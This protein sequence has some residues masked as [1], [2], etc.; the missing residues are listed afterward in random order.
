MASYRDLRQLNSYHQRISYQLNELS[1]IA[2]NSSKNKFYPINSRDLVKITDSIFPLI[3]SIRRNFDRY[4]EFIKDQTVKNLQGKK[5]TLLSVSHEKKDPLNIT[6]YKTFNDWINTY[7]KQFLTNPNQTLKNAILTTIEHA[8]NTVLSHKISLWGDR[9][10]HQ[11]S[12]LSQIGRS[13]H[14]LSISKQDYYSVYRILEVALPVFS[15]LVLNLNELKS[16]LEK[17]NPSIEGASLDPIYFNTKANTPFSLSIYNIY[18]TWIVNQSQEFVKSPTEKL[19][20]SICTT[21]DSIQNS[22]RAKVLELQGIFY[23][24][25]LQLKNCCAEEDLHSVLRHINKIA[26]ITGKYPIG[27]LLM[28]YDWTHL[29]QE[30]RPLEEMFRQIN[31][32]EQWV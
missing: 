4:K 22:I 5:I 20:H 9:I 27:N 3:E 2:R 6:V 16:A 14:Y 13:S 21:I 23:T 26:S 12:E 18:H 25:C 7:T 11:L 1:N 8:K 31:L 29:A 15:A 10:G 17:I 24:S 30:F 19:K 28:E 32:E